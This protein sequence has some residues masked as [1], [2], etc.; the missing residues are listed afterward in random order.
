MALSF[1]SGSVALATWGFSV[2]DIATI[3]GAGR[4]AGTWMMAQFKDRVLL[5]WMNVDIDTVLTRKGLFETADLQKRWD[6]KI[7]LYQNGQRTM[8]RNKYT[9]NVPL[10]QQMDRFSWLMILLTAALDAAMQ[11]S[12]QK[13]VLTR[14]LLKLF[15]DHG[16]SAEFLQREANEHI[17]GW[18]SAAC[19]R[20]ISLK[21]RDHWNMLGHQGKHQFGYIP[22][23][24]SSAVIQFL[25][26]LIQ[27]ESKAYST[28][29]TDIFSLAVVIEELGMKIKLVE[30]ATMSR[31]D[32]SDTVVYWMST[33]TPTAL[34][35]SQRTFRP[36]M[37]VPLTHMEEVASLFPQSLERNRMRRYF[38]LGMD[39]VREDGLSLRPYRSEEDPPRVKGSPF[40][41]E[42]Q[43][44]MLFVESTSTTAIPRLDSDVYRFADW[45]FPVPT[46]A[47]SNALLDIVRELNGSN[48]ETHNM[49]MIAM[50]LDK[51]SMK[52][53]SYGLDTA[54]DYGDALHWFQ[55]FFLGYWYQLL[56][57]L[58]DTTQ[59]ATPEA[60]GAWAWG[61]IHCLNLIREVVCT[62]LHQR[63]QKGRVYML[64]R[65]EILKLA[66][67]LFGGA[68]RR[69]VETVKY[70]AIGIL[71]KL[72][73]LYSSLVVPRPGNFGRF[74]LIDI[75]PSCIPSGTNGVV[76]P[77]N[78]RNA[79]KRTPND[80]I[81]DA[82][83]FQDAVL[84][85]VSIKQLQGRAIEDFTIHIEPDWDYDSQTCLVTYR[86]RG[87]VV[88]RLNPRQMDLVLAGPIFT[89]ACEPE[90]N[91][92]EFDN[93]PPYLVATNGTLTSLN[94]Y[95]GGYSVE[96]EERLVET[97]A[98]C[99]GYTFNPVI[100]NVSKAV[101]AMVC[102]A[103][104]YQGWTFREG[105]SIVSSQDEL[106]MAR[107]R[108]AKVVLVDSEDI[109]REESS[110]VSH[111]GR[112]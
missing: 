31:I 81:S 73:V 5:D 91:A 89:K 11:P 110:L 76:Y 92:E 25:T 106:K 64:Y 70:G 50:S 27:D 1:Q 101:N 98:D 78:A 85:E 97:T 55:A 86:H 49:E 94:T 9:G 16:E 3:A 68:E 109:F 12:D 38:Q 30:T 65:F 71:G 104:V 54:Y 87:R 36:G 111:A 13:K 45:L 29:S 40:P 67:Y 96:P 2:G 17:Q 84:E 28:A 83:M 60:F 22:E 10:V 61:D 88:Q 42:E 103:C 46:P 74:S 69:Q 105:I 8:F 102:L 62:R 51:E 19:V 82:V 80:S 43:D 26:W 107:H 24:E 37:R 35:K 21:A 53:R 44:L 18:M 33:V 90:P 72:P 59:L 47:A 93:S 112:H 48:R 99:S 57:P 4:K 52:S 66:A 95:E 108:H 63:K 7:M 100:T 79:T 77:G 58:L 75:D 15:E 32:E 41:K 34:V 20:N 6:Q 14:L 56:L 23:A 39:A